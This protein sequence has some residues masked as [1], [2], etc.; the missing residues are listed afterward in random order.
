MTNRSAIKSNWAQRVFMCSVGLAL[1]FSQTVVAQRPVQMFDPFY[2]GET[3]V[4]SFYDQY[5]VTAELSYR[6]AGLF[7]SASSPSSAGIGLN[8]IGLNL[9]IDY[10][11]SNHLDLGAYV[12]ATGSA[13]GRTLGLSWITLK[14]FKN[15]EGM[16]YAVRLA[17]DPS[18]DGRSGFPQADLA[19]LYT[20]ALSNLVTS[21]FAIGIR[22][23]QIG[24]QEIVPTAPIL[25]DPG[26]PIV[27]S[28]GP[29][30]ELLRGRARGWEVHTSWS[31]NIL[32]D[33]AGSNMF[34]SLMAEG[35]VYDMLEWVVDSEST[36]NDRARTEYQGG[37]LWVSSGIEIERPSYQFAP[38]LSVP[39]RQWA[40]STGEWP[41]SKVRLG[42]RLML[43]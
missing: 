11:L 39:F 18:S 33:P 19:F 23:V 12:D 25:I 43:R 4:R 3:A 17:L 15:Q 32:F 30:N 14:Y 13:A 16:D 38:F 27:I 2:R 29:A 31:Y 7:Q 28:P 9:H 24:F 20:S 5:A 6:P 34:F 42:L 21:D 41:T 40:P 26:D 8:P 22:R 35:G 1:A 36:V 10:Q 37:T